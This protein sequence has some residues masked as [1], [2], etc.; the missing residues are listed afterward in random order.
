MWRNGLAILILLSLTSCAAP[1]RVVTKTEVPSIPETMLRCPPYP[2]KPEPPRTNADMYEY[3]RA[4]EQW[5]CECN[6]RGAEVARFAT[7]GQ[8]QMEVAEE[9]EQLLGR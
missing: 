1:T 8:Q 9:C 2:G 4:V 5:G 6:Y 7:L 3:R